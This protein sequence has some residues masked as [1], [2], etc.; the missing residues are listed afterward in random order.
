[1]VYPTRDWVD[2]DGNRW[3]GPVAPVQPR[4]PPLRYRALRWAREHW[5]AGIVL[6]LML[7]ILVHAMTCGI[8]C[9]N[10]Q[11]QQALTVMC[12]SS[13]AA[14]GP[15]GDQI[16]AEEAACL[17]GQALYADAKACVEASRAKWAPALAGVDSLIVIGNAALDGQVDFADALKAYCDVRTAWPQLPSPPT[18]IGGCQ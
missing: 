15:I 5:P 9:T 3:R 4:R 12:T 2:S 6:L 17:S 7:G 13:T 14:L 16:R 10:T 11:R 8:G 1:M 18:I